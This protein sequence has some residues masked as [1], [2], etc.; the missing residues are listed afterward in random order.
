MGASPVA[1][2]TFD[3]SRVRIEGE[4]TWVEAASVRRGHCAGCGT[5]LLF[6]Q[7][8]APE[9]VDVAVGCI[10]ASDRFPPSCHIWADA[11]LPW[12]SIDDGLPAHREDV[13]SE[14]L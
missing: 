3:A 6:Q 9:E 13:G 4:V 11:R 12:V 5:S 2:A 7:Q 10:E 14:T 1:W 8:A